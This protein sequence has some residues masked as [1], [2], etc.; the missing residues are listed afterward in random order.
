MKQINRYMARVRVWPIPVAR[1]APSIPMAGKGPM[2]KII[3][4]SNIMFAI[5]PH[6]MAAIVTLDVYKRQTRD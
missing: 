5:Q 6:I 2:P 3:K 1:A 4:G